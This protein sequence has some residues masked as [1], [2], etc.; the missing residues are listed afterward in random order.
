MAGRAGGENPLPFTSGTLTVT[1]NGFSNWGSSGAINAI[2]VESTS[3]L[4]DMLRDTDGSLR[5]ELVGTIDALN[6][7]DMARI[8]LAKGDVVVIDVNGALPTTITGTIGTVLRVFDDTGVQIG[9]DDD[10]GFGEDPELI[11]NVPLFDDYYIGISAE[12]N[13]TYIGLDGT[14]AVNGAA[15]GGYEVIIHRN[16][17]LIG[18]SGVNTISDED[19]ASYIVSLGGN[20]TVNGN[21]GYDTLA[22]GDDNDSLFGGNG[23]D[24]LYGEQGNDS[25]SGGNGQD[26]VSGGLG[27]DTLSGGELSDLLE[28]GVGNDSLSSGSGAHTDT[29][30]GGDGNDILTG[31]LGRD[32]MFG[33]NGADSLRASDGDDTQ[34]G[35]AGNDTL[36][37]G[38][39]NDSLL[40]GTENDFLAGGADNDRLNGGQ[41]NDTL[42]GGA[43]IDAFVFNSVAEGLDLIQD[44][45]LLT[46]D[47]D[48][49]AIFAATGSVV[50]AANLAQFVQVT[51]SGAGADSF[52]GIDA[53]GS[54]GGLSFTIV[55]QVVGVTPTQLFDFDNFLV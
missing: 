49:A 16:P 27:D 47:I 48:L 53:N 33:G 12:G 30:N 14:G 15:I 22:G 54:V 5:V 42:N 21:D 11:F 6:D 10:S 35:D 20:D 52:L 19:G 45:T 31:G 34:N 32:R 7:I 23:R 46:D 2:T 9:I 25:L 41:G 8:D 43:G 39:Q 3:D 13:S 18:S 44:F 36:L 24:Q 55:A 29:L 51:P 40:G 28:G 26:V 50:T 37:G 4:T 1:N 17:T 38:N